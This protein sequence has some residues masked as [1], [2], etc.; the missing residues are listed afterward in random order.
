MRLKLCPLENGH[1]FE[2]EERKA[3]KLCSYEAVDIA[4]EV[5]SKI[6]R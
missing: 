2:F 4:A 3:M 6:R 1:A 5:L